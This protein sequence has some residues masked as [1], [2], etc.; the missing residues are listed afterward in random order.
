M[1][2]YNSFG[3][4][5][6]AVPSDNWHELTSIVKRLPAD[7]QLEAVNTYVNRYPYKDDLKT[8]G[9]AEHIATVA[10]FRQSSG[11][12]EDYAIAK[13]AMLRDA[14]VPLD[15]MAFLQGVKKDGTSHMVLVVGGKVLDNTTGRIT[16]LEE[17]TKANEFLQLHSTKSLL[18]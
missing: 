12:C 13:A 10:Q 17:F 15:D 2:N 16:S 1:P 11:D 8:R 9:K 7:K 18:R 5:D 14:G 3:G 6:N 4:W